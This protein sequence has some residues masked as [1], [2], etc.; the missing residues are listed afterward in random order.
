LEV[1]NGAVFQPL[2][3]F[4]IKEWFFDLATGFAKTARPMIV[5][6]NWIAWKH[7]NVDSGRTPRK[8]HVAGFSASS[9]IFCG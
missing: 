1:N 8:S 6:L 4:A 3:K 7:G 9:S 5:G 2:G